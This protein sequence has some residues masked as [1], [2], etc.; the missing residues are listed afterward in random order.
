MMKNRGLR[1]DIL[2]KAP[3]IKGNREQGYRKKEKKRLDAFDTL[4][5]TQTEKQTKKQ[6]EKQTEKQS[7]KQ[8]EKQREKHTKKPQMPPVNIFICLQL[9]CFHLLPFYILVI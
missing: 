9:I 1:S 2:H 6:S 7:E 5:S 8:R 4:S 3:I